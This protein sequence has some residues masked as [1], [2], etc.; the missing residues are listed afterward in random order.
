MS[1]LFATRARETSDSDLAELFKL[2]E[3]PNIISFA[4]GFPDPTWYSNEMENISYK[5][6]KE[7]KNVALQYGPVP[8][9]TVFREFI[10]DRMKKQDIDANKE[11]ILITSGALQG[12]ELIC[13]TFIDPGDQV[14]IEAPT[15]LGA[16]STIKSYEADILSINCDEQGM[17]IDELERT[18]ENNSSNIKFI[19]T[20]PTFQNPTGK[21]LPKERRKRIIELAK[22][23]QLLVIEDGAYSELRFMGEEV[24]HMKAMDDYDHVIFLGT[25]SKILSPGIRLG[26]IAADKFM[27]DK[28]TYFKQ[29]SDQMTS[30]LSQLIALEA[31]QTGL[32]DQ[33]IDMSKKALREKRDATLIALGKYFSQSGTWTESEGGFYTWLEIDKNINTLDQLRKSVKNYKVAY[34]AGPS[35]FVDKN[36]GKRALRL[37]YSLPTVDEIDKG[38]NKLAEV[39]EV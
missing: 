7:Q 12:L 8:G 19:Y 31:G 28:L 37:S 17:N 10:A 3:T 13:K 1:N 26:W 30:P 35:F 21:T 11:N 16:I 9:L 23:Y 15:Y 32:L 34:V 25:F 22:K 38:I 2:S 29:S 4:G 24:P 27:I 6:L 20:I 36:F 33:Q 5:V 18:L 14:I 39:F